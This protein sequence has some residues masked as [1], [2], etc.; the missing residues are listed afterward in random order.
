MVRARVWLAG[1]TLAALSAPALQVLAQATTP[2]PPVATVGGRR[3]ERSEFDARLQTAERQLAARRGEQPAELRDVLRRQLLETMIRMN[4]LILES[5]RLG[6]PVGSAEA[7]SALKLDPFFSPDG[8]FDAARWNLTRTTQPARFQ[9]ALTATR[10]RLAA[11][12]LDDQVQARYRPRDAELRQQALRQ[13]RRAF[14]EDISL[15]VAEFDGRIHEPRERDVTAYYAAHREEYRRTDRAVLSVSFINEP[16]RTRLERE[17]AAAGAA[18]SARMKRTADSVIAAIRSGI[19]LEDATSK[20]GGPRGDVSVLPEN[21]PG[22]WQGSPAQTASVFKA[23]AGQVLFEAIPGPEGFL[24][25]RVDQVTPA[26]IPPL[27]EVSREI[28]AR[29]REDARAHRDEW[30]RRALYAD[31]RDSLSGPA[32][33]IR[34]AALDTGTVRVP[35]PSEADLDR[36]YRGHLADFSTFDAKTGTIVARTLPQV[37]DEVR[38]RWKRDKRV[39]T[40]RLQAN[41]LSEAWSAGKRAPDVER[42]VRVREAGPLPAGARVDTGFAAAALTDTIWSGGQPKDAGLVSY[43]RGFIVWQVAG[44][45]G[46]HTPSYE[47]VMDA[48]QGVVDRTRLAADERGAR[49]LYERD[50][51]RFGQG[52]RFYFTRLTVAQPPIQDIPLTRAEVERWHKRNIEKY[53]APELVRTKHILI[54]PINASQAADRAARTRADSLLAR[55][56]AGE[57]FD[58]LAAQFSDDPATREKGGDVGVF[59]RGAMLPAFEDAA[60][61]MNAGDLAGP[62]RTEVGYHILECTEHVS[63]HV[64][65]LKLVYSIVGSDLARVRADTIAQRRADSL[66]RVARTIPALKSAARTMGLQTFQF[67]HAADEGMVNTSLTPYFERLL[68]LKPGEVMPTKFIAKGEG[69][70]ITWVDSIAPPVRPNWTESRAAALAAFRAGAGERAMLAKVA[71][72][73]SLEDQGWSL[74]SLGAH[75]GGLT[76][77]KELSASGVSANTMLPAAMDSLVFGAAGHVPA[78]SPGQTSDWVRWPGGVARVRLIERSEP[79]EARLQNRMDELRRTSVDRR[80]VGYYEDLKKRY[81]V[82]IQD[83]QLEA[84]PLPELPPEE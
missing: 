2:P 57:S 27:R 55:I 19:S 41:A 20:F 34:W 60:F 21:F 24:V 83:R 42:Q 46:K 1:L 80:M 56:R 32:W 22:Y 75:W 67:V 61:A 70:W 82:R 62:V 54:S 11:R 84:I 53:S 43:A 52:R 38:L 4:L 5:R 81:P 79:N 12:K 6:T 13:L 37:K 8:R 35:E 10:E 68:K 45:L 69:W 66:L 40:A 74:D 14:T 78:L 63:A 44:R 73:D 39:E 36:W 7:E 51:Q 9:G 48:L 26:H 30:E 31:V 17:D 58:A 71:E 64:Q 28:R 76:R 16:P 47:Q 50:P 77:S 3:I 65:P 49:E 25:V 23:K 29:L 72:L 33:T 15:R 18:W 59:Q